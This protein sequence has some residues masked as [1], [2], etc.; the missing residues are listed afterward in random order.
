M[1]QAVIFDLFGTLVET[2]PRDELER[3][4]ERLASLTGVSFEELR[5]LWYETYAERSS[6]V[7][8]DSETYLAGLLWRLGVQ[9]TT[10]QLRTASEIRLDLF[11][12][13]LV[14]RPDA[15]S[16]L[17]TLRERGIKLGLISDCSWEV[18]QLWSETLMALYIPRPVFSCDVGLTKPDRRIYQLACRWLESEPSLCLFVG[19][20]G[21]RELTGAVAAGLQAIQLYISSETSQEAI[22]YDTDTWEGPRITTLRMVTTMLNRPSW[23]V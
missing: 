5:T 19:D 7:H 1:I 17:Q 10:V 16:T 23:S 13:L 4:L 15:I 6:G 9:A 22:R 20:G 2:C 8:P 12:R 21:S 14:P 18:P 3:M 11:R